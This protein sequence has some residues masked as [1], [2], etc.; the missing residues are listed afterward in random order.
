M[1]KKLPEKRLVEVELVSDSIYGQSLEEFRNWLN[2]YVEKVPA[3]FRDSIRINTEKDE[4]WDYGGANCYVTPRL[5]ITYSRPKV[6]DE[7]TRREAIEKAQREQ[8]EARELAD[9]ER[10]QAKYKKV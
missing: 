10:L 9:L 6:H 5:K 4:D 7:K 3:E 2:D 8:Q 1:T